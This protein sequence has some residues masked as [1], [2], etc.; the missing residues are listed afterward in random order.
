HGAWPFYRQ[1]HHRPSQRAN[2]R[3]KSRQGRG[4]GLCNRIAASRWD[5][6]GMSQGQNIFVVD[7]EAAAR[8]MIGDYLKMHGFEVTVCD[9]GKSLGA[10]VAKGKPDRV[11]VELSMRGG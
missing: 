6:L 1:A 3:G 5:G 4:S 7:D 11:G 2:L 8:D 9:G 10:G